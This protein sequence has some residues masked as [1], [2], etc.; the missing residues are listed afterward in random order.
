M[1]F[2]AVSFFVCHCLVSHLSVFSEA[3]SANM[4]RVAIILAIAIYG[5]AA[6]LIWD[7]RELLDGFLNPLNE[8]PFI[9]TVTTEVTI[10]TEERPIVENSK[11]NHETVR[12]VEESATPGVDNP[13]SV[14]I[15]VNQQTNIIRPFSSALRMRSLTRQIAKHETNAE[16]WLYARAAF[17]FFIALLITW[18]CFPLSFRGGLT[19]HC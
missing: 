9:N 11:Y 12:T 15:Q 16:A 18:V 3:L 14:N 17:L 7:K 8:N 6:K 1:G 5:A 10:T 4:V 19:K 13:Y 2:Y